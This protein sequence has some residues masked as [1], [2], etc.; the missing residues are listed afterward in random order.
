MS[1]RRILVTGANGFI[2]LHVCRTL[3]EQG[4]EVIACLRGGADAEALCGAPNLRIERVSALDA[5]LEME[6]LLALCDAVIHLAGRAHVMLEKAKDPLAEFRR[7]NVGIT[8][9]LANMAVSKGVS[10]FILASSVKVNGEATFDRPFYADDSAAFCGPYGQTKWEAEQALCEIASRGGMEW[11]VVRPPLV[12]GPGVRAN[13]LAL[14]RAVHR[15][16][17]LPIGGV[18]N[19]RSM[20]SVYNLSNL[21]SL[22]VDH[23][24]AINRRFLV[25]DYEDISTPE[26]VLRIAAALHRPPRIIR[27]PEA[28][29]RA[30]GTLLG[31]R[32][33]VE[34]LCSSL[35]LD[36]EKTREVL[37][38][39]PPTSLQFGLEQTAKWLLGGGR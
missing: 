25:S 8:T 22:L 27:C 15:G 12:Y 23:P 21:L 39:K 7:V 31:K 1:L 10:R 11:V 35:V 28:L 24:A 3:A 18:K 9:A 33:T 16:I 14:V 4:R 20:V 17:P 26:L 32:A 5:A 34:R 36:K 2:G 29:L 37:G 13:F 6:P 19:E 30:V 38:W